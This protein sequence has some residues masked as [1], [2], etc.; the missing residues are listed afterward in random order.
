[1]TLSFRRIVVAACLLASPPQRLDAQ[2][3]P[4]I[5]LREFRIDAGHSEA[6][7][8][9]GFLGR[10]VKGQFDDI[11]GTLVYAPTSGSP[12]ASA[13]T[14]VIAVPS[15]HTGSRH[16]DEHLRSSD[17]F[18]AAKYPTIIFQSRS[19]DGMNGR[20][21]AHGSLSMHGVTSQVDIPFRAMP[22]TPIEDPHGS[23]LLVFEGGLR[24][25]RRDF[26]IMGGS[27]YNDWFDEVRSATMSDTVDITLAVEAWDTDFARVH[28]LDAALARVEKEGIAATISAAQAAR[29]RDSESPSEYEVDQL[30]TALLRRGRTDDAAALLAW[31]AKS[32]PQS[33]SA[34][35]SLARVFEIQ[36]RT[37][38]AQAALATALRLDPVNPRAL[39]LRRRLVE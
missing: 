20:Y 29:S 10:P 5:A 7:F 21:V 2:A 6:S 30:G 11:R 33:G 28:H 8:S 17:F 14:V 12:G 27:R 1:M 4:S 22:H 3:T 19:I 15:I 34:W 39:E 18:D 31:N 25:A 26:G 32:L 23:T 37:A 36:H 16:R 24:L 35:A 13:I 9:I 38:D